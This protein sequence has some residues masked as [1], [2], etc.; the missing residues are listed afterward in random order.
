MMVSSPGKWRRRV[1]VFDKS[2]IAGMMRVGK[3]K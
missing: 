1:F 2:K 3:G